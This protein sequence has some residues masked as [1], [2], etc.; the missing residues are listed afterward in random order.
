M[1]VKYLYT[2]WLPPWGTC[3]VRRRALLQ[4]GKDVVSIS[5]RPFLDRWG[6][7]GARL[8]Y[9]LEIGPA[10][11]AYNRQLIALA[12]QERCRVFWVDKGNLIT[13]ATLRRIKR[14]TGALC[15]CYN[16]DDIALKA[17]RW[18][19]H[20]QCLPEYDVYL[21]SNRFNVPELY[22][23]GARKVIL[24]QLGY[25]AETYR[26]YPLAD[27]ERHRLG[28]DVGFIGHWEKATEDLLLQAHRCGVPLRIRGISWGGLMADH[29][30][31]AITEVVSLESPEYAKALNA[32]KINLGINSRQNRNL[33]SGRSFQI[34]A[35][36]GF[37]LAQRTT[38]HQAFYEEGKEAEF[39]DGAEE[40][41]EKARF[42]LNHED[43][44]KK[45]AD[46]GYRR[47][48]SSGY[49]EQALMAGMART[50]ESMI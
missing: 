7:A 44:R 34:P 19:L 18:R 46:A 38:E 17:H 36:G 4:S 8:Q 12:R 27:E 40:L 15:V 3:E 32:T 43:A 10:I 20:F 11:W 50:L 28:A 39:F 41:A 42:Y 45:I 49:S 24:T 21:T 5:Y 30:L 13:P 22:A 47:C 48:I 26:P 23:R 1:K 29:P 37:L 6:D 33:S 35:C 25:D 31:R 14:E 9:R 16:T 2:G